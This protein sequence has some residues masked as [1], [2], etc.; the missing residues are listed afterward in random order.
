ML[1]SDDYKARKSGDAL[2]MPL[3]NPSRSTL[4]VKR[5]RLIFL[6]VS[7]ALLFFFL[8]FLEDSLNRLTVV[9]GLRALYGNTSTSSIIDEDF[10]AFWDT[11]KNSPAFWETVR[12]LL[13]IGRGC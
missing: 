4:I 8:P 9:R 7:F 10:P 1:G 2:D 13:V 5:A 11:D 3:K 12:S 6:L